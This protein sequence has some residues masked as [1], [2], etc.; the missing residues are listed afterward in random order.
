MIRPIEDFLYGQAG[1]Q[2][3]DPAKA[4]E[5]MIAAV[6]SDNPPLRLMMG[7]DAYEVWDRTIAA[8]NE[9]LQAWRKRGE[10]TAFEDSEMIAIGA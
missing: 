4:A 6:E 2:A 3:G 5:L 8:R 10:D 1:K 9:D 7:K